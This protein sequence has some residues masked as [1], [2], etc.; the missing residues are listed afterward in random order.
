M[1]TLI[2]EG[3]DKNLI[4]QLEMEAHHLNLSVNEL[5]KLLIHKAL[6]TPPWE[7]TPN[8]DSIFGMV[9]SQTDGLQYQNTM[10]EE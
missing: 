7:P 3:L 5:A 4:A 9:Q 8:I 1:T 10:R 2:I 6:N